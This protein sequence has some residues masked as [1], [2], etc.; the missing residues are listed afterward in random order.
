MQAWQVAPLKPGDRVE[1]IGFAG[2]VGRPR[3]MRVEYLIVDGQAYGL[4]SSPAR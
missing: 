1:L 4:R 3:L 2:V